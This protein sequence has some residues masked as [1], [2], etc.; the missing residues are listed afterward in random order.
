VYSAQP[1]LHHVSHSSETVSTRRPGTVPPPRPH[2]PIAHVRDPRTLLAVSS[3]RAQQKVEEG[4]S[5]IGR[6]EADLELLMDADIDLHAS[7]ELQRR[8]SG[9]AATVQTIL[10]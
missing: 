9:G 8:R 2:A 4:L 6:I 1:T 7:R 5:L 3:S 10:L